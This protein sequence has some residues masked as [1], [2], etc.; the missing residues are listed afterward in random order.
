MNFN[1]QRPRFHLDPR[2][3]HAKSSAY[4]CGVVPPASTNQRVPQVAKCFLELNQWMY[5]CCSGRATSR[6]NGGNFATF[7]SHRF[8][9]PAV[10]RRCYFHGVCFRWNVDNITGIAS[11]RKKLDLSLPLNFIRTPHMADAPSTPSSM[12]AESALA[13][14]SLDATLTVGQTTYIKTRVDGRQ[15]YVAQNH[16]GDP[17]FT[18]LIKQDSTTRGIVFVNVA[19]K[20]KTTSLPDLTLIA[21]APPLDPVIKV[22]DRCSYSQISKATDGT[23]VFAPTF[24]SGGAKP[25]PTRFCWIAKLDK[26]NARYFFVN[27][28]SK[29]TKVW[30]L[31]EIV[32]FKDRLV[33]MLQHYAPARITEVD[34]MLQEN[35]GSEEELFAQLTETYGPEPGDL[36]TKLRERVVAILSRYEPEAIPRVDAMLANSNVG[37]PG[38]ASENDFIAELLTRYGE[39]A[40]EPMTYRARVEAIYRQYN[41]EKLPSVDEALRLY[42][43]REVQLIAA[44]VKKYGA[45]PGASA[46]AAEPSSATSPG[47]ASPGDFERST[48]TS[49]SVAQSALIDAYRKRVIAMY[50]KYNPVKLASVETA[51]KMYEGQEDLLIEALIKKYGPEP[52]SSSAVGASDGTS[53]PN[54]TPRSFGEG[55][56]TPRGDPAS[57]ASSSVVVSPGDNK[58]PGSGGPTPMVDSATV[59]PPA[60]EATLPVTSNLPA[61]TQAVVHSPVEVAVAGTTSRTAGGT[62]AVEE[63]PADAVAPSPP[64]TAHK[65]PAAATTQ[66]T[67]TVGDTSSAIGER[68]AT[69]VADGTPET[70]AAAVEPLPATTS[71][72]LAGAPVVAAADAAGDTTTTVTPT[73]AA[74]IGLP[75]AD[76]PETPSTTGGPAAMVP[77]DEGQAGV[78]I[79]APVTEQA[80]EPSGAASENLTSPSETEPA[81]DRDAAAAAADVRNLRDTE[82]STT[83]DAVSQAATA[84]AQPTDGSPAAPSEATGVTDTTTAAQLAP[85]APGATGSRRQSVSAAAIDTVQVAASDARPE[86][87]CT[88]AS[89]PGTEST[90]SRING[91]P[92]TEQPVVD[93]T[94]AAAG[95]TVSAT[96]DARLQSDADPAATVHADVCSLDTT[97][98]RE[99]VQPAAAAQPPA[100][101][102]AVVLSPTIE[103]PQSTFSSAVPCVTAVQESVVNAPVP[104]STIVPDPAAVPASATAPPPATVSATATAPTPAIVSPSSLPP[105]NQV[106][107]IAAYRSRIEAIY[108]L[109]A[110]GKL[111]S[112]G[113]LLQR[114][115]GQE[116]LLVDS[117]VER[118]GPEPT[119]A[120]LAQ[121]EASSPGL[122]NSFASGSSSPGFSSPQ[123]TAADLEYDG[124]RRRVIAIFERHQPGKLASVDRTL[125]MWAGNEEMLIQ[126]LVAKFGPEGPLPP[127]PAAAI[128]QQPPVVVP[129]SDSAIPMPPL[130]Q[131][132]QN[133]PPSAQPCT[134]NNA[135]PGADHP[136]SEP[137]V[138]AG[139]SSIPVATPPVGSTAPPAGSTAPPA[140]AFQ[141]EATGSVSNGTAAPATE[142]RSTP[143]AVVPPTTT[144]TASEEAA[145][146]QPPHVVAIPTAVRSEPA[147][148]AERPPPSATPA[149]A[150]PAQQGGAGNDVAGQ[151]S[152]TLRPPSSQPVQAAPQTTPPHAPAAPISHQPPSQIAPAAVPP[153]APATPAAVAVPV[154]L[155]PVPPALSVE[156][157]TPAQPPQQVLAPPQSTSYESQ[158]LSVPPFA[159]PTPAAILADAEKRSLLSMMA[160]YEA[161]VQQAYEGLQDA[162]RRADALRDENSRLTSQLDAV[163]QRKEE[164]LHGVRAL[165]HSA[166][167]DHRRL[168][169]E[170]Q[171]E[172]S[173]AMSQ[174]TLKGKS[175]EQDMER[176]RLAEDELRLDHARV[177]VEWEKKIVEAENRILQGDLHAKQLASRLQSLQRELDQSHA[178][179]AELNARIH[180]H[181]KISSSS[182]TDPLCDSTMSWSGGATSPTSASRSKEMETALHVVATKALEVEMG[183]WKSTA[184]RLEIELRSAERRHK[185]AIAEEADVA[186]RVVAALRSKNHKLEQHIQQ[187]EMQ[188]LA[189]A[190]PQLPA[191]PSSAGRGS[192]MGSG[193]RE[194]SAEELNELKRRLAESLAVARAQRSELTDLRGLLALHISSPQKRAAPMHHH[195][196]S[197]SSVPW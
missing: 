183:R 87:V 143:G 179:I 182:Q 162:S 78:L 190:P 40:T 94:A 70:A 97:V 84:L 98:N 12:S 50:K 91:A 16:E 96:A 192:V 22:S 61:D 80:R 188:L 57:T 196:G 140:A 102:E 77:Q 175:T 52:P 127:R 150:A 191:S 170:L 36:R 41:P 111:N 54:L 125:S 132:E 110:P 95:A 13:A 62:S 2:I 158:V 8:R 121:C 46:A 39:G 48:T 112:V 120:Q 168:A 185:E 58:P 123:Q 128:A 26:L 151:T 92:L 4:T 173:V 66:P 81:N 126:S 137:V 144:A 65:A 42:A 60:P 82:G 116:A 24:M 146:A 122:T 14:S 33:Q 135:P 19:S 156:P 101:Q 28:A 193:G 56:D 142:A 74:S 45:E 21:E 148:V 160:A 163:R 141:N 155:P 37:R 172:R 105:T 104:A 15:C 129:T 103:P 174:E 43:G 124:Y 138:A 130:S 31:P 67:C 9:P 86:D 107:P 181:H 108:K 71:S 27:Q 64:A 25:P 147:L 69:S 17:D 194:P 79:P 131:P 85:Q 10:A 176:H 44:L 3:T 63:A 195:Y 154:V 47:Q 117:L 167:D 136:P 73:V 55:L 5:P 6:P 113:R 100:V 187:L 53:E 88:P 177:V 109:Y 29:S 20:V 114:Y 197:P 83:A 180:A 139:S 169:H 171:M 7:F 186:N 38:A 165:L 34:T 23:S 51:L 152:T 30:L 49:N 93:Q 145:I 99:V 18:F 115:E 119:A 35:V 59:A 134:A 68:A 89:L 153:A 76:G 133:S 90:P 11:C 184:S 149:Q 164:E 75:A 157:V 72:L 106:D 159:W 118:Y 189:T 178:T 1:G 32:D 166:E 161:R